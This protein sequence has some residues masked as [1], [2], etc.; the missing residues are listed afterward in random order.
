[1]GVGDRAPKEGALSIPGPLRV[2]A[3][4]LSS[5][6]SDTTAGVLLCAVST[7]LVNWCRWELWTN[8]PCQLLPH[9]CRVRRT[10]RYFWTRG[11]S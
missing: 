1:M 3:L 5:Q 4:R 2:I 6:P 10:H 8:D 11:K 7:D 9:L